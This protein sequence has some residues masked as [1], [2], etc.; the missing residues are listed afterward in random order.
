MTDSAEMSFAEARKQLRLFTSTLKS[1]QVLEKVLDRGE[2]MENVL[3]GLDS[4]K[5]EMENAITKL[6][7]QVAD[8]KGEVSKQ[9]ARLNSIKEEGKRELERWTDLT[10]KAA[11][12]HDNVLKQHETELAYY[13]QT[14]GETKAHTENELLKLRSE[15]D[16]IVDEIK[17][18]RTGLSNIAV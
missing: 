7:N 9:L 1:V 13:E 3:A 17:R 5:R 12:E 16:T 14:S 2:D 6:T 18:L 15:R 4:K 10:K 11:L 8:L